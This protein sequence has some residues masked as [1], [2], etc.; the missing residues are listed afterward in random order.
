MPKRNQAMIQFMGYLFIKY[1]W[2]TH[3]VASIMLKRGARGS[4][5][6]RGSGRYKD[7]NTK[8]QHPFAFRRH[9]K[10]CK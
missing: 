6:Q 3:S 4:L 5:G 8:K 1:L 9:E 2:S 10:T 7:I